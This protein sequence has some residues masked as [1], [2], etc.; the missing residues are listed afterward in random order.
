MVEQTLTSK[1]LRRASAYYSDLQHK[2]AKMMHRSALP[3]L[4]PEMEEVYA[5]VMNYGISTR[6]VRNLEV[7]SS[8]EFLSALSRVTDDL[9]KVKSDDGDHCVFIASQD[10]A[11]NYPELFYWGLNEEI[12][13]LMENVIGLPVAYHGVVARKEIVN[14][15]A[16]GTRRW[17]I[18]SEDREIVRILFYLTDVLSPD[19]GPF[20]Y[21]PMSLSPSYRDFQGL[22]T[23]NIPDELM[24][25]FAPQNTWEHVLG[26]SGTVIFARAGKMF[27]R[28]SMPKTPRQ[29][30]SF[31]Y[32]SRKPTNEA[33]TTEFSFRD[34]IPYLPKR[35]LS[36]RQSETLWKY[37][38]DLS[39]L[40]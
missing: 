4:S 30:I 35:K 10:I 34:G 13:D 33:L 32:T 14:G 26:P 36:P 20:E 9:T 5:D 25:K 22:D 38:D 6:Q 18:D 39:R 31:Y 7:S 24:S 16:L 15:K 28:G 1:V 17:H 21:V 37:R 19:D 40:A 23:S 3:E 12:L 29:V 27:H 2:A 8:S 11:A